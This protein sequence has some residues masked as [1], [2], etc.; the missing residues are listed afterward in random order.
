[1]HPQGSAPPVIEARASE[2]ALREVL[3]EKEAHDRKESEGLMAAQAAAR[4]RAGLPRKMYPTEGEAD[5]MSLGKSQQ[6]RKKPTPRARGA[7]ASAEATSA[8]KTQTQVCFREVLTRIE[9]QA[10]WR[11]HC[12]GGGGGVASYAVLYTHLA[13][14]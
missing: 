6:T 2:K 4:D 1:V 10:N 13:L 11:V 7:I 14:S 8:A 12:M 5:L 9:V 3:L